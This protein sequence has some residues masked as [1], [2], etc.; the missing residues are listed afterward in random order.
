MAEWLTGC[1]AFPFSG[2]VLQGF[3]VGMQGSQNVGDG[4]RIFRLV[5]LFLSP[6]QMGDFYMR[7]FQ[8]NF[9]GSQ[10]WKDCREAYIKS[11]GGLCERCRSR[12]IITAGV[13]VHHKTHVNQDNVDDP[14][15]TLNFDNLQLLCVQCHADVHAK[16]QKRYNVD[17]FGRVFAR[18]I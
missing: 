13:V 17:K 14:N 12:G 2:V 6:Y 8:T 1:S 4:D 16:N 10:A 3:I 5:R 15:I 11:V 9:Y 18:N 7:T